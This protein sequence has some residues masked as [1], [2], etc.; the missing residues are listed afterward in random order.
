MMTMMMKNALT[1]NGGQKVQQTTTSCNLN[2]ILRNLLNFSTI[3]PAGTILATSERF[4]F[5]TDPKIE[6]GLPAWPS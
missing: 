5:D 2:G 6:I 3:S 4:I 1:K